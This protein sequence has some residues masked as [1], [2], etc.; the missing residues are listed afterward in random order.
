MKKNIVIIVLSVLLV[1][2][3]S[4]IGYD[5]LFLSKEDVR[6][7]SKVLDLSKLSNYKNYDDSYGELKNFYD[8]VYSISLSL[9]GKVKVCKESDC[10]YLTNL[11]NVVDMVKMEFVGVEEEQ[12]YYFLLDNGEVYNYGL[13]NINDGMFEGI[14][15]ESIENVDRL[16]NYTYGKRQ[17]AGKVWGIIAITKDGEYIELSRGSV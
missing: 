9:D 11:N 4:Y 2:A 12:Q 17:Y 7:T 5:K 3:I 16:I 8:G 6:E 13:I 14:K 1:I 10:N 15:I